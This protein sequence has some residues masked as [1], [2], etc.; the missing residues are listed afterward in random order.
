MERQSKNRSERGTL[1]THA[2]TTSGETRKRKPRTP[3]FVLT[4][5]ESVY[6]MNVSLCISFH[7][8]SLCYIFRSLARVGCVCVC[9]C[10]CV[11]SGGFTIG[12]FGLQPG[13]SRLGGPRAFNPYNFSLQFSP[14]PVAACSSL[15][16]LVH[17]EVRERVWCECVS[18]ISNI[19]SFIF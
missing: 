16:L 7:F 17:L 1:E 6:P 10:T 19:Y 14:S 13:A 15:S 8:I 11:Y 12:R 2:Q 4:D 18:T 9:L 5:P 3:T